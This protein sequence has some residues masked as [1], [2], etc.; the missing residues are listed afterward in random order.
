MSVPG[1]ALPGTLDVAT[2][3]A[4]AGPA[5]ASE[6]KISLAGQDREDAGDPAA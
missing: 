1:D 2:L 3:T 6:V 5:R 4:S